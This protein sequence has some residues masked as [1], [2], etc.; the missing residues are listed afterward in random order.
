[1]RIRCSQA[2]RLLS[3]LIERNTHYTNTTKQELRILRVSVQMFRRCAHAGIVRVDI[4][5]KAFNF[6]FLPGLRVGVSHAADHHQQNVV[7]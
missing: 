7:T 1:M 2:F 4:L 6:P 5:K 3:N